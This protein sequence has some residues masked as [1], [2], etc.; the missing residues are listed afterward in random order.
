MPFTRRNLAAGIINRIVY[1]VGGAE[2]GNDSS[3]VEA[4]DHKTDTWTEKTV[5]PTPRE[6][7]GVGVI[8]GILYAVGGNANGLGALTTV[9]ACDGFL[10]HQGTHVDGAKRLGCRRS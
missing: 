3:A 2:G 10:D 8:D 9:Q 4:Y 6:N 5:M 7:L 1:A